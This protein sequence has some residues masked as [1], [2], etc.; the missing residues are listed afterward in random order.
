MTLV[1]AAHGLDYVVVGADSRSTIRTRDYSQGVDLAQKII[2]LTE[3]VVALLFGAGEN[4]TYHVRKFERKLKKEKNKLDGATDVTEA[5]AKFC[6]NDFKNSDIPLSS[7]PPWGYIVTGLDAESGKYKLPRSYI[8]RS[9]YWFAKGE[10]GAVTIDGH[11]FIASYKFMRELSRV[12][13][14][15]DLCCLVAQSIYD[16]RAVDGSV[17]G[18]ISIAIIDSKRI[19]HYSGPEVRQML[20]SWEDESR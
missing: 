7:L 16:T 1:I 9:Q 12:K 13:N 20:D 5:F 14:Y 19:T 18:R 4:A 3:H 6:R 17:G 8:L 10:G 2:P 15:N 11:P